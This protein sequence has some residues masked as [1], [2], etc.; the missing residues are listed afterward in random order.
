MMK[1]TPLLRPAS[2]AIAAVLA[3]ASTP[4]LAQVVDPQ[5]T[6]PVEIAPP[7]PSVMTVAP[8]ES[9]AAAD[10]LPMISSAPPVRTGSAIEAS[11]A[12]PVEAVAEPVAAPVRTNRVANTSRAAAP[13]APSEPAPAPVDTVASAEPVAP[14]P[15][16][17]ETAPEEIFAPLAQEPLPERPAVSANGLNDETT[18]ALVG[19]AAALLGAGGL[20][21]A[22]RGRKRTK[23][24]DTESFYEPAYEQRIEPADVV[25]EAPV[26][27]TP[28]VSSA[29]VR[30]V[31]Q[32]AMATTAMD[33]DAELIDA[34]AAEAPSDENPFVT[35]TKR[36]RRATFLLR[37]RQAEG[38]TR[39]D[40][41]EAVQG[42]A[43][44]R[45]AP[46]YDWGQSPKRTRRP[47]P[48]IA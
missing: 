23:E 4:L 11:A 1:H 20:A 7:P 8:A 33:T 43:P 44:V 40:R 19:G 21:F 34:M 26:V 36:I 12:A 25:V 27:E 41:D 37:Q 45:N 46:T 30:P 24:D 16:A 5:P 17:R 15:V 14:A 35:R 42:F 2:T 22:M 6:A 28:I 32:P 48:A 31:A 10:T 13:A 38:D 47:E 18:W 29:P 9:P 3:F 39:T